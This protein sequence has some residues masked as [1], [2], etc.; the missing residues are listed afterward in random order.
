MK[1]GTYK[2]I[3]ENLTPHNG[4]HIDALNGVTVASIDP[5]AVLSFKDQARAVRL[6]AA[7]PDLLEACE[8]GAKS[9]HHPACR[10]AKGRDFGTRCD[11]HVA[12]CRAAIAK[13][14]GNL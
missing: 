13:A 12:K 5:A 4:R 6:L 3:L 2:L 10:A 11:C 8:H 1:K 9:Y 14:K 7:A